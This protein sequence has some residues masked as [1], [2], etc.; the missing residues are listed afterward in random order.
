MS[1]CVCRS[2]MVLSVMAIAPAAAM[3]QFV[4]SITRPTFSQGPTEVYLINE[5]TLATSMIFDPRAATN[6]TIGATAPG[7]NGLA[8]DDQARRLYAI[9]T[10][11][12]FSDLWVIEYQRPAQLTHRLIARASRVT[13][14]LTGI[15]FSGLAFDSTRNRMYA[16]RDLGGASGQEGLWE[17][18][19]NPNNGPI[20]FSTLR[21]EFE[22]TTTSNYF[23][24][25]LDYA[26]DADLL[27]VAD[28][29]DTVVGAEPAGRMIYSINPANIAAGLTPYLPY[30][31]TAT[32]FDGLAAGGGRVL[33][34]SDSLDDPNTPA[35]EGNLGEH[36]IIE[37]TSAPG[38]TITIPTT[39][40]LRSPTSGGGLLRIDP[41]GGGAYAPGLLGP[42]AC[43]PADIANTDG[44]AGPDGTV[45]N[46][47]F[48]L[49][50]QAF[51][52][53]A[54]D[55]VRRFADIA[56]TDGEVSRV[57]PS[58]TP[59]G[60]FDLTVDNGD[61]TAFFGAFFEACN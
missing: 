48:A 29:D 1:K 44:E 34:L 12:T 6:P 23:S 57:W 28:D 10:N 55:P 60:G 20:G 36:R 19:I 52:A 25:G 5:S 17:I 11:G 50:F 3:A 40:P 8:A 4:T 58:G 42:A 21:L 32:D 15:V 56:N 61:F 31:S 27:F 37:Y 2:A 39:Y 9:T 33:C 47:D 45:D 38:F 16:L 54:N 14:P 51:F 49:F 24:G 7:F 13:S 41:S 59:N 53:D 43:S 26:P 18:N 46:G 35:N 30:P 22:P